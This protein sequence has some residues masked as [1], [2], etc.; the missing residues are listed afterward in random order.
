L[1]KSHATL[2]EY[3]SAFV[4]V[5]LGICSLLSYLKHSLNYIIEICNSTF[6]KPDVVY[7][8]TT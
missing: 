7:A 1:T 6:E 8:Q 3:V 5:H 4:A 2:L